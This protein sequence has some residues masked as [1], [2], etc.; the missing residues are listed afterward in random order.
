[1]EAAQQPGVLESLLDLVPAPAWTRGPDLRLTYVNRRY[2]EAAGQPDAASA[3]VMQQELGA[4]QLGQNGKA[5]ARRA[6]RT[7]HEQT[8]SITVVADGRRRL[9]QVV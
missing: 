9:F 1:V 2:A 7:G 3:L 4:G 6:L 8:E 5:L